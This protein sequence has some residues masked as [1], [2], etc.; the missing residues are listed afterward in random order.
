MN[1]CLAGSAPQIKKLESKVNKALFFKNFTK[2]LV[3]CKDFKTMR[4]LC[5]SCQEDLNRFP[6]PAFAKLKTQDFCPDLIAAGMN[7]DNSLSPISIVGDGNCLPRCASVLA[8]GHEENHEEMRARI[9]FELAVNL[10]QYVDPK[11]IS[12]DSLKTFGMISGLAEGCP[13]NS[14]ESILKKELLDIVHPNKYM[15]VW[16]IFAIANI[17]KM[18][19]KSIYP[20]RGPEFIRKHLHRN[21]IPNGARHKQCDENVG[22]LWT[23]MSD[24]FQAG[25]AG[26][27]PNHFVVCLPA[28]DS[29]DICILFTNI[30]I[31]SAKH[32]FVT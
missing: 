5:I 19:I 26:W 3:A 12:A 25:P 7:P 9:V 8:Y 6:C 15:G 22:I 31:Q 11:I 18:T 28:Q 32:F 14:P 20:M 27:T 10:Q 23:S 24:D 4:A 16:Q 21:I 30:K 1:L 29:A 2:A 13:G 17:L